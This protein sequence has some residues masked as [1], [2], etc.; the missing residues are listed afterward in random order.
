M[1]QR[2]I[3]I[4][5]F[6]REDFDYIF[7]KADGMKPCRSCAG[8][9][10][11]TL[12]YEPSTR[13]RLSFESA[14]LR[15][16]GSTIGFAGAETSSVKKGESVADTVRTVEKYADI[17]VMR[18]P[19]EGTAKAA[20]NYVSV[21]IINAGDGGHE[22]PT[23]TLLDLYTIKKELGKIDGLKIALCGDLKYGRTVHSLAS[24]LQHYDVELRFV[25]PEQLRFPSDL[26]TKLNG[27]LSDYV[28][29]SEVLDSDV[30]YMTRIQKERFGDETEYEKLRRSCILT[31]DLA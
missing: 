27:K 23:Q 7:K 2:C 26:R 14:M 22:H 30:I 20:S 8:K 17:I 12:F 31:K 24:A 5:D 28:N 29:L 16:G 21:P 19:I 9:I 25:S 6:S 3:S 1:F 11:A 13:T 18:H 15:L 4:S 10:M